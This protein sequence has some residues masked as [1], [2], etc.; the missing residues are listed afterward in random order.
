MTR[1]SIILFK[2]RPSEKETMDLQ[3][4]VTNNMNHFNQIS[5]ILKQ[6]VEVFEQNRM[7]DFKNNIHAYMK[8]I[9]NQQELVL[10][11]WEAYLSIANS[12]ALIK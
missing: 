12:I 3:N 4:K 9:L 6:E 8:Q 5:T 2:G 1:Y 11:I 7:E 10:E